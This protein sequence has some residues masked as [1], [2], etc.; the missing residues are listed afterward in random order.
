MLTVLKIKL[1]QLIKLIFFQL[2][3]QDINCYPV[4]HTHAVI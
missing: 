1:K 2:K 4:S 3:S